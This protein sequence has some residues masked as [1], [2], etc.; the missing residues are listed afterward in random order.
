LLAAKREDVSLVVRERVAAYTPEWTNRRADDAGQAL[1][2]LF[3]EQAEPVL[4]RLNRIPEKLFVECLRTAGVQPLPPRPAEALVEFTVSPASKESQL[5][6][7]GFQVA[8]RPATG[9]GELVV[10]E[11]TRDL[12][13][14]PSTIGEIHV[15]SGS[16]FRAVDVKSQDPGFMFLPFSKQ[17]RAGRAMLIGLTTTPNDTPPFPL[18]SIAFTVVTPSGDPPP[19]ESGGMTPLPVE[20][21]PLLVWEL[22]D[23]GR[24]QPVEL[25]LDETNGLRQSG[26]VEL[27][28]ARSWRPDRPSGLGGT[29]SLRWLRLRILGGTFDHA[30]SLGLP[31][32]NTVRAVATRT[33][34]DEV[35]EPV[36]QL[37]S[38]GGNRVQQ[39]RVRQTP[40]IA[41]SL[42]LVIDEGGEGQTAD[43]HEWTEVADLFPYGP[44]DRVYLFDTN[45]G[46][47][48]FGDGLRGAT[49]PP[50]FRNVKAAKYSVGGGAAGA[51]DAGE[52]KTLLNAAPFLTAV[53]NRFRASGGDDGESRDAVLRRGPQE[54]RAR[55]RAITLADYELLAQRTPGARVRRAHAMAGLHPAHLGRPIPGVVGVLVVPPDPQNG[56]PPVPN[57]ETLRAVAGFLSAEAA[58]AGV[59]V[60][61]AAARFHRMRAE[62]RVVIAPGADV[63]ATVNEVLTTI[64]A[65]LHPLTGGADGL[66]WP[67]GGALRYTALVLR[68]T[69]LPGVRAIPV[70]NLV[71]DGVRTRGCSDVPIPPHDLF[72][73][74]GHEVFAV[75]AEG[76]S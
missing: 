24:F 40:V 68:L 41:G 39:M 23:S 70:L 75:A 66:G 46:V 16:F 37:G 4:H 35:L 45:S 18:V 53:T 62:V 44:D 36:V 67:F 14:T 50:G 20:S 1:I 17:A 42:D 34:H 15:Q 13:A 19:V 74:G 21:S 25:V 54:I 72:W 30:P 12:V 38:A 69:G 43:L 49:L 2:R 6:A 47:V 52:V 55:G 32:L 56:Q 60:V 63:G 33:F 10:F 71:A 5:V 11:T 76:V 3:G 28:P 61:A 51:V 64:D 48:T 9:T 57:E 22:L 59:D 7:A 26:I 27:R 29:T 8:A 65:Y 73:P 31:R 58:L